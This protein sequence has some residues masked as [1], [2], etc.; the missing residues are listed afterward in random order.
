[1]VLYSV[2]FTKGLITRAPFFLIFIS[3]VVTPGNVVSLFADDCKT[4]GVINC[5]ADH[6]L[7]QI[8]IDNIYR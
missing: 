8:N 3:E 1:M 5:P 2:T 4:S 6:S 7:F